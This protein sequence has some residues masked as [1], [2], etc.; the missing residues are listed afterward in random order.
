MKNVFTEKFILNIRI[1][2]KFVSFIGLIFLVILFF[3][4]RECHK[5]VKPVS[6]YQK[7]G[8]CLQLDKNYTTYIFDSLQLDSFIYVYKLDEVVSAK[9]RSFYSQRSFQYAW[10]NECGLVSSSLTF[11]DLVLTYF[12]EIDGKTEEPMLLDTLLD[13][14]HE[15]E[16]NFL[17]NTHQVKALEFLLTANFFKYSTKIYSGTSEDIQSLSWYIPRKKRD[18]NMLL[19]SL[20]LSDNLHQFKEPLNP[21]YIKLRKKLIEY[22]QIEKLGGLDKISLNK[23]NLKLG[24]TNMGIS[25]LKKLLFRFG[26]WKEVDT[27]PIFTSTLHASVLH[28][29]ARMGLAPNGMVDMKTINEINTPMHWRIKQ[30]LINL[31]RLR[32]MPST[33]PDNFLLVNIPAY[34]LHVIESSKPIF[35]MNIIVGKAIH[36]TVIFEGKVSSIVLNPYWNIPNSIVK[37]ELLGHIRRNSNYLV[38]NNMEMVRNGNEIKYRQRPGPQ[39]ALGKIK[40]LFP[41]HYNIYL[42][43]AP[44]KS[45]FNANSRAFSHGCIRLQNARKLALYMLNKQESWN[46]ERLDAILTSNQETEI[47][48]SPKFPVFIA[49]F[50]TWVDND[51]VIHFRKDIYGLD[52]RLELEMFGDQ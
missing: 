16:S 46:E 50:T 10:F 19:D 3:A 44:A 30:I 7:E 13:R 5:S 45:L 31:E 12:D 11:R 47:K 37:N 26:D 27:S 36:K 4:F 29:Q 2:F 1:H 51:E 52:R 43:D 40:F 25:L 35:D 39:N 8:V 33:L 38:R 49:Y 28:F 34:K 42:H 9:I 32:W 6:I 14:A 15:D 41:N 22:K 18:Y 24:D 23:V 17:I 20:I 48:I 21:Y